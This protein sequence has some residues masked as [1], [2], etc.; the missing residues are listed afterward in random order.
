MR[1]ITLDTFEKTMPK[2]INDVLSVG[3]MF[4]VDCGKDGA[5]VIMEEPEYKILRE[6]L[7]MAFKIGV[8]GEDGDKDGKAIDISRII[9]K[10]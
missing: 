6:T 3:D 7:D 8:Y 4:R 5:V 2:V 10:G 1:E 9:D